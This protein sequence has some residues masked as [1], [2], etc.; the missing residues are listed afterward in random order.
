MPALPSVPKV[1]KVV[2]QQALLGAT[3][4]LINRFFIQYTGTAPTNSQLDTFAQAVTTSWGTN[5]VP[6]A[7]ADCSLETVS[8]ED[9]TS[10]TSAVGSSSLG[11][12]GTRSGGANGAAMCV[13]M[14]EKM[15]RRY[16]GGHPRVYLPWGSDS[17]LESANTWGTA[18]TASAEAAWINFIDDILAAG[19][20]GAGTLSAVNVSYYAGFTNVTSPSG[21]ARPKPTLRGTPVVDAITSYAMNPLVGSQRRRNMQGS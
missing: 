18:F 21:R 16:R 7:N 1:V 3:R 4:D 13:V 10:P 15:A 6:L 14:Q 12:T 20:T 11:S 5:V 8:C 9:L 2:L 19:W 17:D